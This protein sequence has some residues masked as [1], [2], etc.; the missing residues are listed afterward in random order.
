MMIQEKA[1]G[2]TK[3]PA[4]P[5]TTT[6]GLWWLARSCYLAQ[7]GGAGSSTPGLCF[8]FLRLFGSRR[9]C[10]IKACSFSTM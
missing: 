10:V 9:F 6:I 1:T 8:P 3:R 2:E 7:V 5:V 4:E